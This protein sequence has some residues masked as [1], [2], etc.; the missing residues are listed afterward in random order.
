MEKRSLVSKY[1]HFHFPHLFYIFDSRAV[2]SLRKF[3]KRKRVCLP[4]CKHGYEKKCKICFDKEYAT[5]YVKLH[6][7]QQKILK[8]TG[9]NLTP[10]QMDRLLLNREEIIPPNQ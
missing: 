7:W 9:E 4:Q 10:R 5:F 2:A 6:E 3:Q 8:K 1:L